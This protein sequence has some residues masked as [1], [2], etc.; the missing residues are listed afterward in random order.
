MI[1]VNV[2][3]LRQNLP[4]F[5]NRVFTG[6]EFLITKNGLMV[7]KLTPAKNMIKKPKKRIVL[8]SA[9]GMWKDFK[10]E[11]VEIVNKWKKEAWRGNYDN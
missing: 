6:E 3:E 4:T 9:F 10:G 11:T 7:A 5:I 8:P 1:Q 2:S